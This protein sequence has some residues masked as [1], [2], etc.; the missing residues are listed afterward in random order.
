MIASGNVNTSENQTL[1]FTIE[2]N[3]TKSQIDAMW[4]NIENNSY[5]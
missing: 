1:N 5:E 4:I 3:E 2:S